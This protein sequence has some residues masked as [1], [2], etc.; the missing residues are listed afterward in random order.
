[1]S[2]SDENRLYVEKEIKKV[3]SLLLDKMKYKK[4][5]YPTSKTLEILKKRCLKGDHTPVTQGMYSFCRHCG[6]AT[7]KTLTV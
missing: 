2:D 6:R 5:L 4:K 7:E 3:E 1:M